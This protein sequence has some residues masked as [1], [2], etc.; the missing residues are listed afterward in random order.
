M[1]ASVEEPAAG[2]V[3]R[4]IVK[5]KKEVN[6]DHVIVVGEITYRIVQADENLYDIAKECGI[7]VVEL[8]KNNPGLTNEPAAGTRV[9]IPN[10]IN[11][12][13]YIVH[14]CEKNERVSSLLKRWKVDEAE[15]REKNISVGTHVF[16]NQIVLIPITP[17]T[18]FYWV[19]DVT[20]E[21]V[22][23]EEEEE[24][25]AEEPEIEPQVLFLDEDLDAMEQC[26]ADPENANKRYKVALMVPL[27]LGEMG[28][29]DVAKENVPKAQKS[30]SMA[31]LQFYE[32][33]IMAVKDLEKE[34]LKL[35]LNVFDVTEN[36]A[37]AE[38]AL[39]AIEGKD[40]DLI[41]GP[42]YGK[43]F[44]VIEDY[45][46]TA[47]ITMINPLSNRE[48]VI[49]DSPNVVKVKPGNVIPMRTSSLSAE[50]SP[51][52]RSS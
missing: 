14:S 6:P 33:F 47:G 39:T 48:S 9:A 45:A 5:L 46:K 30:R 40:Y 52:T 24:I 11:E 22:E 23:V 16:E 13:D 3:V 50:R 29:L 18:N 42:F 27:Y 25:E 20:E 28:K 43:S 4:P 31:F 36:V 37:S 41:V 15:F 34:G 35:D 7:D 21:I 17:V 12:N 38:R 32:G 2:S 49:V 19:N 51:L 26:Y 8:K 10:I 44:T 1:A